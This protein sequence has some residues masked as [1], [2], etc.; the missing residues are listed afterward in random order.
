MMNRPLDQQMFADIHD[1]LLAL[2]PQRLG[3]WLDQQAYTYEETGMLN[4][5]YQ[6]ELDSITAQKPVILLRTFAG[7][8]L[9][10]RARGLDQHQG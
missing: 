4:Q 1:A 5:Y 10:A 2:L 3:Q 8:E 9:K 6:D 7:P